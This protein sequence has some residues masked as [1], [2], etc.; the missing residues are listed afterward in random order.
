[1][2]MCGEKMSILHSSRFCRPVEGSEVRDNP[3]E[4]WTMA[5]TL[6]EVLDHVKVDEGEPDVASVRDDHQA[7]KSKEVSHERL[8]SKSRLG[9][10]KYMTQL[11]KTVLPLT[12]RA[13][14]SPTN[15]MAMYVL[16]RVALSQHSLERRSERCGRR[17]FWR[18]PR[19]SCCWSP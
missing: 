18:Q 8:R 15:V 3:M 14:S 13:T 1:M 4:R 17:T 19:S 11:F 12:S 16:R 5:R 10:Y 2:S 6:D 7:V 9:P